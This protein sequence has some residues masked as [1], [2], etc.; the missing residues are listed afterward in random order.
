MKRHLFILLVTLA[1]CGE[2][3]GITDLTSD[4]APDAGSITPVVD[5]GADVVTSD[6]DVVDTAPPIDATEA[7][8]GFRRVFVTSLR[9]DGIQIGGLQGADSKCADMA[10]STG[11][12]ANGEQWLAWLSA[13][14]SAKD[15]L[16]FDGPY[17]L[18]NGTEIA[19][20]KAKFTSGSLLHAIDVNEKG[21]A[22]TDEMRVWTGTEANGNISGSTCSGWMNDTV[23]GLYGRVDTSGSGWT[24]SSTTACGVPLRLYCFEK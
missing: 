23:L 5:A 3:A 20:D 7:D 6:V 16:V 2:I 12:D 9:W 22:P 18:L 10:R 17:R 19:P 4:Q 15:R 21:N 11:L 13:P 14:G 1:G 24:Q 8:K